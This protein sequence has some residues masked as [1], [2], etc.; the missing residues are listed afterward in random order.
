M[1]ADDPTRHAARKRLGPISPRS[2]GL[3]KMPSVAAA[4]LRLSGHARGV[5]GIEIGDA[6]DAEL[7]GLAAGDRVPV[8]QSLQSRREGGR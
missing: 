7:V 1:R 4:E 2:N 6:I 3:T 5:Q 8:A